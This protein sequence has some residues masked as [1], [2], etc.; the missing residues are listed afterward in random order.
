[1]TQ[2]FHHHGMQA[3][4]VE[5]FSVNVERRRCTADAVLETVEVKHKKPA[6][7]TAGA[8][9][10]EAAKP[11]TKACQPPPLARCSPSLSHASCRPPPWLAVC[12]TT[13]RPAAWPLRNS[14]VFCTLTPMG[15]WALP[16][17]HVSNS[18]CPK[19]QL[20]RASHVS[21]ESHVLHNTSF[22]LTLPQVQWRCVLDYL[23]AVRL[24]FVHDQCPDLP[25]HQLPGRAH[26]QRLRAV[27]CRLRVSKRRQHLHTMRGR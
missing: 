10:G 17:P 23:S 7:A 26:G 9:G 24:C 15:S 1:M 6:V 4:K 2:A 12:G 8:A 14:A 11:E 19:P 25:L 20:D 27:H 5:H 3:L 16:H 18:L 22:L 13:R 21:A